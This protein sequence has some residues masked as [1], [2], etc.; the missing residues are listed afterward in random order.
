[1]ALAPRSSSCC[2]CCCRVSLCISSPFHTTTP[3]KRKT[4]L[5]L[6]STQRTFWRWWRSRCPGTTPRG[7]AVAGGHPFPRCRWWM[8][9]SPSLG[10]FLRTPPSR[11][12]KKL[13][14][15]KISSLEGTLKRSQTIITRWIE[16][17][18]SVPSCS[19]DDAMAPFFRS[20][21]IWHAKFVLHRAMRV[22]QSVGQTVLWYKM[23]AFL[24]EN[25]TAI[26]CPTLNTAVVFHWNAGLVLTHRKS[27]EAC[28]AGR[29]CRRLTSRIGWPLP[30]VVV[31]APP[32]APSA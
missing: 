30:T 27:N 3:K 25:T 32:L 26:V 17:S 1:M 24:W 4:R 31:R 5:L 2:W 22:A 29:W 16:R 8:R 18:R 23:L 14:G 28:A 21:M 7:L 13:A 10:F 20:Q 11:S 9:H 12:S 19:V 15:W 6:D